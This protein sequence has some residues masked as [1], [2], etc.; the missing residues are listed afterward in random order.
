MFICHFN[1]LEYLLSF[2]FLKLWAVFVL[3]QSYIDEENE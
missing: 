1:S 3:N 2:S